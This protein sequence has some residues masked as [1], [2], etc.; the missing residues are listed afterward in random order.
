MGSLDGVVG[1]VDSRSLVRQAARRGEEGSGE[2]RGGEEAGHCAIRKWLTTYT[3]GV[4]RRHARLCARESMFER[5][6]EREGE[7]GIQRQ[8]DLTHRGEIRREYRHR[9]K[10]GG[11]A[12]ANEW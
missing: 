10:S 8:T 3:R 5:E 2:R 9:L 1:I 4:N 7:E 11:G 6:R 12:R